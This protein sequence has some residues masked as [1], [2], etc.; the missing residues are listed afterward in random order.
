[1]RTYVHNITAANVAAVAAVAAAV[2]TAVVDVATVVATTAF[3]DLPQLNN[4]KC[5]LL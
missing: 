1:M 4:N 3:S 5:F 2:I